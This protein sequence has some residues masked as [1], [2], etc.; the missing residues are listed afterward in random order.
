MWLNPVYSGLSPVHNGL[1]P[2]Y[3]GLSPLYK[4]VTPVYN[5][6]CSVYNEISPV[7]AVIEDIGHSIAVLTIIN[8]VPLTSH[9]LLC[10]INKIGPHSVIYTLIC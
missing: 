2:V 5:G 9:S 6:L 8:T 3:S 10:R 7:I 1:T 4:G